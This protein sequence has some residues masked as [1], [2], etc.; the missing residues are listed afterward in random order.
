M[1]CRLTTKITKLAPHK[2][3]LPYGTNHN[4]RRKLFIHCF[5]SFC[6]NIRKGAPTG[7][8]TID[9]NIAATPSPIHPISLS[10]VN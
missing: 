7:E 10:F 9:K 2:N 8:P 1:A 5:G 4:I 3:K 6:S